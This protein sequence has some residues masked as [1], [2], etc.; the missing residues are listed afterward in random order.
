MA[1]SE[2]IGSGVRPA[3]RHR[4]W[5]RRVALWR[6]I[7]GMATA[8]AVAALI[9]SAEFSA[10][11]VHRTSHLN[12]RIASLNTAVHQLRRQLNFAEKKTLNA[13]QKAKIDESL[14]RVLAAHDLRTI[15]LAAPRARGKSD[16]PSVATATVAS[17]ASENA[18]FLQAG[19][20]GAA[21]ANHVYAVWWLGR[22]GHLTLASEFR[23]ESDGK[24]TV[25]M[26]VAPK[27]IEAVMVTLEPVSGDPP[28]VPT[29][30]PILNGP[31]PH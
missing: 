15:K 17:S 28:S 2:I 1:N 21:P 6:A 20:L 5:W 7:A 25:P 27:S 14:K 3:G 10:T 31:A 18:S 8:L 16:I 4:R 26:G 22:H 23:P 30:P 19:G 13:E 29:L 11:L 12:H 24:A 9:V